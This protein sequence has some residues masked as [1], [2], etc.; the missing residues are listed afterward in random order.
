MASE[1][2]QDES[3]Y[4]RLPGRRWLNPFGRQRLYLGSDHVL[5]AAGHYLTEEYMRFHFRDIQAIT[6]RQT[7]VAMVW[8]IVLGSTLGGLALIALAA[9]GAGAL[10]VSILMIAL[11]VPLTVNIASGPS[12]VCRLRTIVSD[13]R[14]TCVN[15]LRAAQ[16]LLDVLAPRIEAAQAGLLERAAEAGEAAAP[17]AQAQPPGSVR[18]APAHYGGR[19]H[20]VVFVVLLAGGLVSGLSV[21][22][23]PTAAAAP[24]LLLA[25]YLVL[26]VATLF[27]LVRQ[28]ET[29]LPPGLRRTTWLTAGY[30]GA[31]YFL[32][33]LTVAIESAER[34]ASAY[35]NYS[36]S[37]SMPRLEV[38]WLWG[39]SVLVPWAL[40][41]VGLVLLRRF[42]SRAAQAAG[43]PTPQVPG[44]QE[45]SR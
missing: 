23:G 37:M 38:G 30:L 20:A 27:A 2:E 25:V 26:L 36:V 40:G 14:L 9:P 22:P 31:V 45:P 12:C 1:S 43:P 17:G 44:R 39:A 16:R 24:Y 33:I 18:V 29:D 13:R 5:L 32:N 11:A 15:R 6:V 41:V 8:N 19:A 3:Q 10:V 7:H 28:R 34:S 35:Y 4:Q 42:R 21:V